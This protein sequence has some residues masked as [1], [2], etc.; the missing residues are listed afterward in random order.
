MGGGPRGGERGGQAWGA[1]RRET[2][3]PRRSDL[4]SLV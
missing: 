3:A 1:T 4:I 2:P